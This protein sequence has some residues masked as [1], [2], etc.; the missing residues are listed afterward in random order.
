MKLP[1]T[2][3][4]ALLFAPLATLHAAAPRLTPCSNTACPCNIHPA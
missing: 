3:L 4:T 2:L 1:L